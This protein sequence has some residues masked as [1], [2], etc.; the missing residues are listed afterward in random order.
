MPIA[1][2]IA[3]IMIESSAVIAGTIIYAVGAFFMIGY[4]ITF[5]QL[6]KFGMI[7][8]YEVISLAL[9]ALVGNS[10]GFLTGALFK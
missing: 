9:C 2:L 7:F 3:K 4:T 1:Y 8:V 6:V 5:L 10:L